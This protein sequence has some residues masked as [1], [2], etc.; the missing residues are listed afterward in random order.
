MADQADI[1]PDFKAKRFRSPPYPSI[2]LGKAIEC[3]S[4][5]HERA[6]HHTVPVHVP[7]SA[8]GYT[9]KSGNLTST[10]SALRQFGLLRGEGSGAKRRF[11]LTNDAIRI[12]NDPDPRSPKR[13]ESLK[14]AALAPKI[15]AELWG[16]FGVAGLL[17]S[18][19]VALKMYLTLDRKDLGEA[20]Y[21]PTAADEL[22]SEYKTTIA[23]ADLTNSDIISGL[24]E[25]D[26]D[27]SNLDNGDEADD[28]ATEDEFGSEGTPDRRRSG[29]K[30]AM[31]EGERELTTGLL[32]KDAG[33]RLIV[34]GKIGPKEIDRLIAKLKLDKEILAEADDESTD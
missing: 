12:I 3:A 30:V 17:G 33:F 25:N 1:Q 15:H 4:K 26:A 29:R 16:K 22:L 11:T 31:M 27:S 13:M 19:D 5:L 9:T 34:T 23:F 7:A 2:H 24:E 20:S 18:M 10:I 28:T 14:R 21:S 32:S 8:W 6:Q